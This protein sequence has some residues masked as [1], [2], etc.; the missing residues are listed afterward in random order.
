M[1]LFKTTQINFLCLN[2]G[3][4]FHSLHDSMVPLHLHVNFT[5]QALQ[6][7][8]SWSGNLQHIWP[9]WYNN[10]NYI[11]ARISLSFCPEVY[12]STIQFFSIP[13]LP[14]PTY[15]LNSAHPAG[16][17]SHALYSPCWVQLRKNILTNE[18]WILTMYGPKYIKA[19][20]WI[21]S[22]HRKWW[23]TT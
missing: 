19:G 20:S 4:R 14:V 21:L 8:K 5:L 7:Q 6:D 1:A 13:H 2:N 10:W 16:D 15:K 11:R 3:H 22:A 12:N 9:K 17:V 18:L 23:I